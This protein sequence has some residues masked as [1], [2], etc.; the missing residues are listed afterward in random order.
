MKTIIWIVGIVLISKLMGVWSLYISLI[1]LGLF[2]G[3]VLFDF[4]SEVS[5]PEID[6]KY[7]VDKHGSLVEKKK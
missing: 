5:K 2:F 6:T 7:E 4:L 1:V 3:P